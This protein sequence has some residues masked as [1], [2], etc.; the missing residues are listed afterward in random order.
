M[1][2][3]THDMRR[4]RRNLVALVA[5]SLALSAGTGAL[6][7]LPMDMIFSGTMTGIDFF[8]MPLAKFYLFLFLLPVEILRRAGL[9]PF[10]FF[11]LTLGVLS[12]SGRA[13]IRSRQSLLLAGS[14]A[15]IQLGAFAFVL[16][17]INSVASPVSAMIALAFPLLYLS[18]FTVLRKAETVH[19]NFHDA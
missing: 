10:V 7:L 18:L 4:A 6:H 3:L 5:F 17:R 2:L 9:F 19:Q 12:I 15:S 14:M 13:M 1:P 16:H 11:F 8:E